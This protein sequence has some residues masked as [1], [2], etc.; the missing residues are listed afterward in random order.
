MDKEDQESRPASARYR[1]EDSKPGTHETVSE[2]QNQDQHQKKK[3]S[4]HTDSAL[5]LRGKNAAERG[6]EAG[7]S[8]TPFA[9]S[10]C[11]RTAYSSSNLRI[12]RVFPRSLGL[13]L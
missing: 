6:Q 10:H 5:H 1:D 3:P 4:L 7:Q 11:H 13:H 2:K 9:L 8:I 12:K